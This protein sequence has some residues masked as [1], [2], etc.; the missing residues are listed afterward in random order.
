MRRVVSTIGLGWP[1]VT[2]Y[3]ASDD[4]YTMC[5]TPARTAASN[6]L[7]DPPM[8][9]ASNSLRGSQSAMMKAR[10]TTASQPWKCVAIA[11]SR[12]S[13]VTA[14]IFAAGTIGGRRSIDTTCLILRSSARRSRTSEPSSP[15]PPVTAIFMTSPW[16]RA[17]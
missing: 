2:P 11:G 17:A 1:F 10:C 14:V 5:F 3:A 12:T 13:Q 9:M 4:V 15:D 16:W 7:S 6:T 8:L